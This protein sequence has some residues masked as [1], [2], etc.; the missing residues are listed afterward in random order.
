MRANLDEESGAG[1]EE[2]DSQEEVGEK[3]KEN[4]IMISSQ[5]G[6]SI[7]TQ[8]LYE[9]GFRIPQINRESEN[10][11]QTMEGRVDGEGFRFEKVIAYPDGKE[12]QVERLML[13][14]AYADP[15]HLSLPLTQEE[16]LEIPD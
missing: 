1:A 3:R 5:H 15:Q 2:K 10:R 11:C 9:Y 8:Y 14:K 13:F 6:H 4:P 16:G 12:D 7:C